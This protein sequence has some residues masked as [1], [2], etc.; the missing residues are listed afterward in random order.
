[1]SSQ[2]VPTAGLYARELNQVANGFKSFESPERKD[3]LTR[4]RPPSV[5]VS[6]G[7]AAMARALRRRIFAAF[8]RAPIR[9]PVPVKV[10]RQPLTVPT[11]STI[12]WA[13]SASTREAREAR[14]AKN[15]NDCNLLEWCARKSFELL[16][17]RFVVRR[18]E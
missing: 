13:S 1:M 9:P 10:G 7:V 14:K 16:T 18:F 2:A 4:P 17:P 15:I 3:V 12:V 8:R 11:A 6:D 5:R